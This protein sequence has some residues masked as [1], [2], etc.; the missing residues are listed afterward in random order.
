MSTAVDRLQAPALAALE[1]AHQ[2]ACAVVDRDLMALLTAHVEHTLADGPAPA[3]PM[4]DRERDVAAVVDQMLVDV[5]AGTDQIVQ[6][7]N[8]HFPDGG[9]ADVV[10][11]AYIVE[12]R[13][14]LRVAAE[15]LWASP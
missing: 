3:A 6:R 4:D 8:R 10:M 15:R 2:R 5:S 1:I 13:T 12:A 14:R 9:L 7:A 11:A